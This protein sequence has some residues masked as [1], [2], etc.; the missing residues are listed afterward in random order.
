MHIHNYSQVIAYVNS[1]TGI[2]NT[3]NSNLSKI[4]LLLEKEIENKKIMY[5]ITT[6]FGA[7]KN[8]FISS[9][10]TKKLQE[11][12]IVSHAVG[13]GGPFDAPTVKAIILV[14]VNYLSK[15]Y[16]GVR[17]IVISTLLEMINKEVIPFVPEKGS[18]GSSGDLAP[19]AHIILVLIGKG[20]AYFQ[21][22]LMPGQVALQK[23]HMKPL[24]LEAK[25]GLALINN[26][27]TMT[28]NSCFALS[29]AHKIIELADI[30]GALS[31]EALR[32]TPKAYDARIHKIKPHPGQI[33]VAKNLCQLLAGSTMCDVNKVQDNYSIRCMPQ[34]HGAIREAF[35]YAEKIVN[36][37]LTSVTDNPLIFENKGTIEVLSGGNFHGE[38]V[39]IAMDTLGLALC[40]Y[41]NVSDRRISSLLDPAI[42]NGLPAFLAKE[43]GLNSGFMILQYTTA[44]LVSENK[45]FAHPASVDSIPTSANVEDLVSMGTIAA[46]KARTI[47]GNLQSILTIEIMVAC[48]AIDFRLEKGMRLGKETNKW[49]NKIRKVVPFFEKDDE[50]YPY[51]E[52]L[53]KYLFSTSER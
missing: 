39:A 25:E 16:S 3:P 20:Q 6:G 31:A 19:S 23:A 14:I 47:I 22:T 18:V 15:G 2:K 13:Q 24:V 4:R 9:E 21:G 41:G 35:K 29:D 44:S 36:T 27:A 17:P 7:F 10:E 42:N 32:A 28:A 1:R 5:G 50:Y 37:E 26:T 48:Q 8:K 51:I 33:I 40:E 43:G 11:N 45:I 52:K 12:L 34:I 53:K 46:R 49:Y 38:A 30:A